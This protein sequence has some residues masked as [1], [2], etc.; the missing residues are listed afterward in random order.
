MAT[1]LSAALQ[2]F[3]GDPNLKKYLPEAIGKLGRYYSAP[4]ELVCAARDRECRVFQRVLVEPF[5]IEVPVSIPEANCKIHAEIQ[6]LFLYELH[7]GRPQPRVIC[8]SKSACYLCN[9]FFH[10][11]GGFHVPRTHGRL[12]DKWILP[13]WLDIPVER[14][15]NLAVIST[16][17]RQR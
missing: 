8:S 7:P 14:H 17:L 15:L 2:T 12:Y 9:L 10:L 16:Q 6:L 5:R 13:H 11:Y 3:S 1:H 4:T